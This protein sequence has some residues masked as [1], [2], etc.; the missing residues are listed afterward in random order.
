MD[1]LRKIFVVAMI[2]LVVSTIAV[3]ALG[4]WTKTFTWQKST[5][6]FAVYTDAG[7]SIPWALGNEALGVIADPTSKTF[8]IKN[9]GTVPVKVSVTGESIIGATASWDPVSKS[10]TIS[11][12]GSSTS[13]T[14]TLSAFTQTDCNYTF[15]FTASIP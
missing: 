4:S 9:D 3:Y 12:V 13:M 5:L 1:K 15:T 14:L 10:V 6:S 8:Y 2:C 11:V 7:L